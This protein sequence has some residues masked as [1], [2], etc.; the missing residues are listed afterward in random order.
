MESQSICTVR[1]Q[2]DGREGVEITAALERGTSPDQAPRE[3]EEAFVVV[4]PRSITLSLSPPDGS[5]SNMLR[6]EIM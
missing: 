2:E 4:D 5:A 6:G 3:G 1:V